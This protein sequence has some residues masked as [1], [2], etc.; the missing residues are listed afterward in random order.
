MLGVEGL[1]LLAAPRRLVQ[2]APHR[3]GDPVGIEDGA[4]IHVPR[5]AAHGLDERAVGAK[6]SLLVGVEDGDERDLRQIEPLAQEVDAD[7]HV[8][9][10]EA[11][12]APVYV[13][14]SLRRGVDGGGRFIGR[15]VELR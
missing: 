5:R 15:H 14:D 13:G 3:P 9:L 6:E 10:P 8:E 1:L 12:G 2:A 11:Q 4:P 7:Q